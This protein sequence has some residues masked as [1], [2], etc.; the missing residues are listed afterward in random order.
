MKKNFLKMSVTEFD[1]EGNET[2]TFDDFVELG[3][4]WK[5]EFIDILNEKKDSIGILNFND[6]ISS[7][8]DAVD[9][10]QFGGI[11][12]YGNNYWVEATLYSQE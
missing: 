1:L 5:K 2:E 10:F 7:I 6:S 12:K 4:D 3:E 9:Q 11:T 8:D